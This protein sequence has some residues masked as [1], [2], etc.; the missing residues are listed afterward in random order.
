MQSQQ[1]N[2]SVRSTIV[3]IDYNQVLKPRDH[4]PKMIGTGMHCVTKSE[5]FGAGMEFAWPPLAVASGG[6]PVIAGPVKRPVRCR[7]GNDQWPLIVRKAL[8]QKGIEF[9]RAR[10]IKEMAV[11]AIIP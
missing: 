4:F 2:P 1:G 10:F 9:A 11:T 6:A 5:V 3:R 8:R 7:R